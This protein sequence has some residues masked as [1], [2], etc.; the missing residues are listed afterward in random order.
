MS[1]YFYRAFRAHTAKLNRYVGGRGAEPKPTR[2]TRQALLN[3]EHEE[4]ARP[5]RRGVRVWLTEQG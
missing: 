3:L 2:K 5:A 1:W 4:Q